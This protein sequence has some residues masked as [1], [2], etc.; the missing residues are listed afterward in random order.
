MDYED[1]KLK[2]AG[3]LSVEGTLTAE[4][5]TEITFEWIIDAICDSQ[6]KHVGD[7]LIAS[8]EHDT[9]ADAENDYNINQVRKAIEGTMLVHGIQME[10]LIKKHK[11]DAYESYEKMA[12]EDIRNKGEIIITPRK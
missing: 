4:Y 5:Y 8:I 3:Y 6:P 2:D 7:F 1:L 10:D 12:V 9:K 11:I